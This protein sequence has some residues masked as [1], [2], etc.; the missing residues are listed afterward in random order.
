MWSR[1]LSDVVRDPPPM[2][3]VEDRAVDDVLRAKPLL[4][5]LIDRM[6]EV[7]TVVEPTRLQSV[8]M[9]LWR[10]RM[11]FV[12]LLCMAWS[13]VFFKHVAPH[14]EVA[15]KAAAVPAGFECD[16]AEVLVEDGWVDVVNLEDGDVDEPYSAQVRPGAYTRAAFAAELARRLN[17]AQEQA[18]ESC[19]EVEITGGV[20]LREERLRSAV[21]GSAT[22]E[23]ARVGDYGKRGRV[24]F[25]NRALAERYAGLPHLML[26][27]QRLDTRLV[28][29]NPPSPFA[30]SLICTPDGDR[31]Y[32]TKGGKQFALL[33]RSGPNAHRSLA[34][35]FLDAT[36]HVGK[37]AYMLPFDTGALQDDPNG[38]LLVVNNLKE[39]VTL[40]RVPPVGEAGFAPTDLGVLGRG[41]AVVVGANVRARAGREIFSQDA[42][43]LEVRERRSLAQPQPVVVRYEDGDVARVSVEGPT[44]Q[45][46]ARQ[47]PV[48]SEVRQHPVFGHVLHLSGERPFTMTAG[49]NLVVE[50]LASGGATVRMAWITRPTVMVLHR[51]TGETSISLVRMA[52]GTPF[53]DDVPV[54]DVIE[55]T[56]HDPGAFVSVTG[57]GVQLRQFKDALRVPPGLAER[58]TNVAE[59]SG[60]A[61]L[62]DWELLLR[63]A[64]V[65]LPPVQ[66]R[67]LARS[68]RENGGWRWLSRDAL[69]RLNAPVEPL[70]EVRAVFEAVDAARGE[71][72]DYD[73][74]GSWEAAISSAKA[75]LRRYDRDATAT[76]MWVSPDLKLRRRVLRSSGCWVNLRCLNDQRQTRM[77]HFPDARDCRER[78]VEMMEYCGN[79]HEG[80]RYMTSVG[81]DVGPSRIVHPSSKA[82]TQ[83]L[84]DGDA[85]KVLQRATLVDL[86]TKRDVCP[87]GSED[88]G[89]AATLLSTVTGSM[90]QCMERC[91]GHPRC[92][93]FATPAPQLKAMLD[94]A[95]A[96]SEQQEKMHRARDEIANA[97]EDMKNPDPSADRPVTKYD[98]KELAVLRKRVDAMRIELD[99]A[100]REAR[101]VREQAKFTCFLMDRGFNSGTVRAE[102][103]PSAW[104]YFQHRRRFFK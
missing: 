85:F 45:D 4:L 83:L 71:R 51:R 92:S 37:D 36:D 78:A 93:G 41:K 60:V 46:V 8:A 101:R 75:H 49:P 58:V 39:P 91:E 12:T 56:V 86:D 65:R 44:I 30:C 38:R 84:S 6:W 79:T 31:L 82:Y 89:E 3:D 50:A 99:T 17:A 103:P 96:M 11:L 53:M 76:V 47:L 29:A 33:L 19:R 98:E 68:M 77:H 13:A 67:L 43:V 55:A 61:A 2:T 81:G 64:E 18:D 70:M 28:D 66:A 35:R 42:H 16:A 62:A 59:R 69:R 15:R 104:A 94:N 25:R 5:P 102:M 90:Q 23:R 1:A 88:C 34:T 9:A 97:E 87:A 74:A 40:Q 20:G 73:P 95:R 100:Q 32:L 10:D 26:D 57:P 24:V 7:P 54:Q 72:Q 48:P 14:L 27:G 21:G 22:V 63:T 52:G 80:V